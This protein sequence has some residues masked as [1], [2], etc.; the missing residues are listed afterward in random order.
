MLKEKLSREHL[1]RYFKIL[2]SVLLVFLSLWVGYERF[3]IRENELEE[4]N[5]A[6][7]VE[8]GFEIE[9]DGEPTES[10]KTEE[11]I[12]EDEKKT[13]WWE[14]PEDILET[15]REGDD[16]LVLVNKKYRLPSTYAPGDL[17]NASSSGIRSKGGIFVRGILIEDLKRL[18]TDAK[19]SGIDISIISAYRSY[20]AQVSTHQK[21][22]NYNGGSVAAAD[23]ISARPGHSQ[24][25][26]G[27]AVDFSSSEIG[28]RLGA[29]FNN[30]KAAKWLVENGW[31]YGFV[32]SYPSGYEAVTGYSYESWHYRYIGVENAVE[33]ENSGKIL[34]VWLREKNGL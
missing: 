31:K 12:I 26:L 6:V 16:L 27:T 4:N 32:L 11:E 15:T 10:E 34:E 20:S 14:Y 1:L 5:G 7:D 17:V 21:W 19:V 28:D 2:I 22:V 33:W 25:Q 30:T 9:K 13:A 23:K 24:H 3:S 29:E 8:E 18:N